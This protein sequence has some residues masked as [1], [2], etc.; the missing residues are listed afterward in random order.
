MSDQE[1]F[2]LLALLKVDGVG[3]IMGKKLLNSFG[4]ASAIFKAKNSDLAAVDGIG[5][6]LIK[7]LKDKTIFEKAEKELSFIRNNNIQVSFF[8]D[9]NYPERLKHCFDAPIL[10][11]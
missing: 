2:S 1:L 9:E 8:Q 7:N 3:D 6:V 5:L 11:F 4:D 10:I